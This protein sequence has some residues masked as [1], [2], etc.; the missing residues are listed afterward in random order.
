MSSSTWTQWGSCHDYPINPWFAWIHR[1]PGFLVSFP[2]L[3]IFRRGTAAHKV[4][5][6]AFLSPSRVSSSWSWP[7]IAYS[8]PKESRD[9]RANLDHITSQVTT[10]HDTPSSCEFV[11]GDCGGYVLAAFWSDIFVPA[12]QTSQLGALRFISF[13]NWHTTIYLGQQKAEWVRRQQKKH[14]DI[15]MQETKK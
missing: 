4:C 13:A 5:R 2:V 11:E 9:T 6:A 15:K 7:R 8:L 10:G 14:S 12:W 1:F 3:G